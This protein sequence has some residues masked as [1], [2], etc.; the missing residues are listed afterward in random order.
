MKYK[1]LVAEDD[2]AIRDSIGIYL[3]NANYDVI[4]A[5]DGEEAIH[6]FKSEK[7]DLIIMDLMMPNLSGE[8]AIL[9]L[10]EITY[11][12]IIILSA[13]GED[14]D[15][16]IGLNIGADDYITKPFNPLELMARVSSNIRRFYEYQPNKNSD[17]LEYGDIKLVIPEKSV[18]VRD[19]KAHLTSIEY[20]ILELLMKNPNRVFSVDEIY[21]KVWDEPAFDVKTVTVHI[22]RIREKIEIDPK[23]P[24]YLKVAWGLGYKFVTK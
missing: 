23:K 21:E 11:V 18:Y 4:E 5:K 19:E 14:Y 20:Q 16:I 15:K 12:P 24:I 7:I 2:N 22:R 13:K 9:E 3:R 17:I 6:K 8:E 10:R 1:I